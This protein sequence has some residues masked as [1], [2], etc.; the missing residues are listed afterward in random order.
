[1]LRAVQP[2]DLNMTLNA[3]AG[4]LEGRGEELGA[5]LETLDG[6]LRKFNPELPALIEDLRLASRVSDTYSDVLPEVA[7]ILRDPPGSWSS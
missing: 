4:A 7:S 6:Y 3:I 1:M 5:S 2:A